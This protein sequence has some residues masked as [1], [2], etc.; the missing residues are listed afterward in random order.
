VVSQQPHGAHHMAS[1][2]TLVPPSANA[3]RNFGLG[4]KDLACLDEDVGPVDGRTRALH[5]RD[6]RDEIVF[7]VDRDD[8]L[9]AAPLDRDLA[10]VAHHLE[11]LEQRG[12]R[13]WRAPH[14]RR[15]VL[16]SQYARDGCFDRLLCEPHIR[17]C[18]DD[19]RIWHIFIPLMD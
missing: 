15:W 5:R 17:K 19:Q 16:A 1:R 7:N 10:R 18:I 14:D 8:W 4:G 11:V 9:R 12:P 13:E 2:E 3:P 6:P